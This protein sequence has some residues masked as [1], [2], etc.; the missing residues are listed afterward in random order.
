TV[1]LAYFRSLT[2]R[3]RQ[4]SKSYLDAGTRVGYIQRIYDFMHAPTEDDWMG[5][6][7][8][9]V[10]NGEITFENVAFAYKGGNEVLS[11][12]YLHIHAG[13][14]FA[15]CGMSG[16]GK[17]T[18][19]YM[20][21]GF[22]HAR[23]GE[24]RIDGQRITDCSL[25]SIRKNIGMISQ[26]VLLFAGSIKDNLL[27]G[28]PSARDAEIHLALLRAGMKDYIDSLPDGVNTMIGVNGL[29]LSG[30]QKQ[31]IAIARIYLK[32]PKIIIFDEATSALDD[33][34]EEQI[35]QAWKSVLTGRTS[36]VIAHRQS[37]VMLCDRAA[38]MEDGRIAE[39]GN[40]HDL[41]ESSERFRTLFAVKE[42]E[43]AI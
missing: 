23:S 16:C 15:L 43:N 22:Y 27:L 4:V 8:L 38:M 35:H 17:T 6:A 33:E 26:D 32:D 19:G 41:E 31:R 14:H 25:R 42:A 28:K 20:M 40:P 18:L 36:I 37:A 34:T 1:V 11:Q 5:K 39:I 3:V 9:S 7:E 24:I 13:E 29:G 2:G 21:L 10:I 12:L 30:G